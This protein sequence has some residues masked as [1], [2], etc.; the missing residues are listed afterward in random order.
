MVHSGFRGLNIVKE[1]IDI[2]M[3]M[4]MDRSLSIFS[5]FFISIADE[6]NV[7][8]SVFLFCS[9]LSFTKCFLCCSRRL[10]LATVFLHDVSAPVKNLSN[11]C[12]HKFVVGFPAR[13]EKIDS[14]T[15]LYFFFF[16]GV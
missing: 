5:L 8:C 3:P 6:V 2:N 7:E 4:L 15:D 13:G 10:V 9:E 11:I 1:R 14:N 16:K 12:V